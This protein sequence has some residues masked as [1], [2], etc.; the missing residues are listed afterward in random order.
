MKEF[1]P[2]VASNFNF[3]HLK[4]VGYFVES[5]I[6]DVHNSFTKLNNISDL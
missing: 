6:V 5:V 4:T 1:W 3:L 2:G